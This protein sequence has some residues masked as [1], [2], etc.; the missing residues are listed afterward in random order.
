[1]LREQSR[2]TNRKMIELA[3]TVVEGHILLPNLAQE[4][5]PS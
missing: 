1:M 4:S 5:A 3:E 2:A